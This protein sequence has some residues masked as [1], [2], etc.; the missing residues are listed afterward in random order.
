[1]LVVVNLCS[2]D[3]CVE[4]MFKKQKK[5]YIQSINIQRQSKPF[6]TGGYSKYHDTFV[7]RQ[8]VFLW[9]RKGLRL[10]V[11][12]LPPIIHGLWTCTIVIGW[13]QGWC[14]WVT[15]NYDRLC[16]YILS[17]NWNINTNSNPKN[18]GRMKEL[19]VSNRQHWFWVNASINL[20]TYKVLGDLYSN[21]LCSEI[22]TLVTRD[23]C[24]IN[25]VKVVP[26]MLFN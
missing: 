15:S 8:M 3:E 10:L 25:F 11:L 19:I 13:H 14:P 22:Y 21:I 1:M 24:H 2:M 16:R 7:L 17:S 6:K 20:W 9:I 4:L 5:Q 12:F 23:L 18:P 26:E